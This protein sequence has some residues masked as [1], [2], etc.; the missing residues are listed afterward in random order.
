MY[1]TNKIY[2]RMKHTT[3]AVQNLRQVT[4][5]ISGGLVQKKSRWC[6]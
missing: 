3:F 4:K 5:N 6:T 2:T 1:K